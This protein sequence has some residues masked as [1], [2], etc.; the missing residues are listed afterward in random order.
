MKLSDAIRLGAMLK[1]QGFNGIADGPTSC[2]LTAAAEAVGVKARMALHPDYHVLM[3]RF[4]VLRQP[5]S[6]PLCDGA[7]IR[8]MD[9]VWDLNDT[10]RWTRDQIADWVAT[11]EPSETPTPDAAEDAVAVRAIRESGETR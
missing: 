4:P 1:P 8:V 6:C 10:H 2:A 11:V 7:F 5:G 9:V 3:D